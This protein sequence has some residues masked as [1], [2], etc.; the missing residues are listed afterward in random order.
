MRHYL[1]A[2][3]VGAIFCYAAYRYCTEAAIDQHGTTVADSLLISRVTSDLTAIASAENE[4]ITVHSECLPLHDLILGNGL[5]KVRTERE[6]Y[7]Y[8]IRCD[9]QQFVVVATPP[10]GR[11]DANRHQPL[12]TV[13]QHLQAREEH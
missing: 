4:N 12:I 11:R 10:A 2:F 3:V 6:G 9:E 1:F 7:T 13:N 8:E 5:Q